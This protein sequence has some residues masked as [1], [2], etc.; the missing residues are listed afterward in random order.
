MNMQEMV[1]GRP[2]L[3]TCRTTCHISVLRT[4]VWQTVR[5]EDL[6]PYLGKRF[7]CLEPR[8]IVQCMNF[9]HIPL[10]GIA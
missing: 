1:Q 6:C 8:N 7:Q 3:S 10:P 4:Q 5:D 2:Q 9:C